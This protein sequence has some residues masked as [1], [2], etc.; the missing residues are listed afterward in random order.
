MHTP[1]YQIAFLL[2][3]CSFLFAQSGCKK[4]DTADVWVATNDV[5]ILPY[6]SDPEDGKQYL[7]VIYENHSNDTYRKIKCQIIERKGAKFDTIV[8]VIIP[9]TIFKPK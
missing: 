3:C 1:R 6:K 2:C 8:K 5:T 9:P 7:N 4:E